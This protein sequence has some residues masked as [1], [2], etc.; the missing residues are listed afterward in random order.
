[1]YRLEPKSKSLVYLLPIRIVQPVVVTEITECK[2]KYS[3]SG[4]NITN[5]FGALEYVPLNVTL[6]AVVPLAEHV[7]LVIEPVS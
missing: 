2:Y 1:M 3:V 4:L 5:T 7:P 6:N